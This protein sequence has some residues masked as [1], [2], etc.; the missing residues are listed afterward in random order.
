MQAKWSEF[1]ALIDAKAL[2]VQHILIGGFY[3]LKAVDGAFV[4]DCVLPADETSEDTADFVENYKDAGN[5]APK[6]NVIQVLG[7]DSLFLSPRA[8]KFTA[9]HG[10]TTIHDKVLDMELVLRGG[11]L[12]CENA[13]LGD[14]LKLQIIDKDNVL[15][16]GGS[17]E[18]P[19]ILGEYVKEWYVM[20]GIKNELVDVSISQALPAGLYVRVIYESV[21]ETDVVAILNL[22]SYELNS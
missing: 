12:Y 14:N 7:K 5:R 11:V 4:V 19:T 10:Q 3:Y 9:T 22:I 6:S 8:L 13:A 15:G 2:S 16:L 21:G 20:P 18:E 17:S 1:K